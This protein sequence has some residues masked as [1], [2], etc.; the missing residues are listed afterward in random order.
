MSFRQWW[1]SDCRWHMGSVP[2][3][4][5]TLFALDQSRVNFE[6]LDERQLAT[7][8]AFFLGSSC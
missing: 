2:E 5:P 3:R 1:G 4:L 7:H 6:N 8:R